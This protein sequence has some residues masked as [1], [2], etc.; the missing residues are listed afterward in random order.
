MQ[1]R[2]RFAYVYLILGAAVLVGWP[3]IQNAIWPPPPKKATQREL[4]AF[5]GTGLI[6]AAIRVD[7]PV[8]EQLERETQFATRGRR[9]PVLSVLGGMASGTQVGS[10]L[11]R[12]QLLEYRETA[13]LATG[14]AL[15][16]TPVG[17]RYVRR[18]PSPADQPELVALGHTENTYHLRVMLNSKGASV[19]QVVLSRFQHADREGLPVKEADG[20]KKP[21]HLIPITWN[22][23]LT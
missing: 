15:G 9:E 3:L 6:D 7:A 11:T 4:A 18:A 23:P 22:I 20:S 16:V 19:Q 17:D 2:N 21:L 13:L 1:P 8:L 14:G 12:S 10:D 5:V